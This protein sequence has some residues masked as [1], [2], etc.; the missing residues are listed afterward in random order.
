M[1]GQEY[2][3]YIAQKSVESSREIWRKPNQGT[4]FSGLNT[5]NHANDFGI[6]TA[7]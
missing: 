4:S 3:K 6:D 2:K 5:G 1:T 7:A